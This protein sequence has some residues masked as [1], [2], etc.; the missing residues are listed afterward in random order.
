M[1]GGIVYRGPI[2]SLRG[3]YFFGDF[4]RGNLW[5]IPLT[6]LRDD[7]TVPSAEFTLRNGDLTPDT[8]GI[9]NPVAF[10]TDLAG[11]LIVVDMDGELFILEQ[12][13]AATPDRPIRASNAATAGKHFCSEEWNGRTVRWRNGEILLD[14]EGFTCVRKH[15]EAVARRA[16]QARRA[17]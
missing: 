3:E 16:A 6:S 9:T 10:G 5:S 1:T 17:Q 12:A 8:G 15:Y 4:V 11:N 13:P 2:D 14:G 7:R